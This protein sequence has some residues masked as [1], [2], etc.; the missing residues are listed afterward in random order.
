MIAIGAGIA[1]GLFL[2][3][4]SGTRTVMTAAGP[5]TVPA[6]AIAPANLANVLASRR[7]EEI[8][9]IMA[10]SPRLTRAEAETRVDRAL[11]LIS[12]FATTLSRPAVSGFGSYYGG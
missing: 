11:A 6:G 10:R 5:V 12:G 7:E 4:G 1:V 2:L 9:R 8:V 3:S